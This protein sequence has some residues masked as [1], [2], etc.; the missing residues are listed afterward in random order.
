ME[1]IPKNETDSDDQ[2]RSQTNDLGGD[3]VRLGQEDGMYIATTNVDDYKYRPD[4][5]SSMLLYEWIQTSHKCRATKKE[6]A[7]IKD[8]TLQS[9]TRRNKSGYHQFREGHPMRSTHL[10]KCDLE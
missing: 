8:G 7:S 9:G 10:V 4:V 3:Q 1:H 5:Y 6:I 2:L